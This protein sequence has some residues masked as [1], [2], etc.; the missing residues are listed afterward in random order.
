M[1]LAVKVWSADGCHYVIMNIGDH[2]RSVGIILMLSVRVLE[3]RVPEAT[4]SGVD[5]S[6]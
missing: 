3:R 1:H 5:T 6:P 4:H 2:R